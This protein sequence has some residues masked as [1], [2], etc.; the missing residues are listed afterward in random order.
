MVIDHV[1]LRVRDC[2]ASKRFYE[3]ALAP[4]GYKIVME[5][6]GK[7]VGFGKETKAE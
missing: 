6:A 5:F 7:G 4:L 3:K 2:A 1:G